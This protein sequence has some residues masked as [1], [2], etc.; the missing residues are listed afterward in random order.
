MNF[1]LK[2][3]ALSISLAVATI[4]ASAQ[5]NRCAVL[6]H[7]AYLEKQNPKRAQQRA[8]FEQRAAAFT[9]KMAAS[10]TTM[11]NVTIP[12]VVHV[13]Y[14]SPTQNISDAQVLS[15]IE[16]L[17]KDFNR[18][19]ADT[20]N[21]PAAFQALGASAGVTFCLAQIDPLGNPTNGIERRSTSTGSFNT[22]DNI[23]FFSSG[24]LDAWDPSQYFNIW[25]GPLGGGLLGYAE[26][27]TGALSNTYGVVIGYDCFGTIGTAAA[28]FDL[29]RTATHEVGHCFNLFHI[30]GD[31]GS[32]C[33]GS[34]NVA[35][36]PNQGGENYFCPSYPNTDN[37]ATT[38]P[39]VMHM[40][41]MDYTDDA[42]MNIFTAGQVARMLAVVNSAPYNQLTASTVCNPPVLVSVDAMLASIQNPDGNECNSTFTP[43]ITLK[44]MGIDTLFSVDINYYVDNNTA[45]VYNWTGVLPSQASTG[46]TLPLI[47]TN[48][49]AHTFSVFT[50]QP[51]STGDLNTSND[52]AVSS[53]TVVS[54]GATLPY[55]E[56]FEASFPPAG[57][58]LVNPDNLTTFEQTNAAAHSGTNSAY[59]NNFDY[60]SNGEIDELILPGIDLNGTTAPELSFYLAYRL[61]TSPTANPNYS[62][63]LEILISTDCGD[64][65]NS[66][67]KK[68]STALV[69]TGA[70]FNT[71][72]AFV[73]TSAQWRRDSIDL[74]AFTTYS[75]VTIKFHHITDYENNL[76]LDD[77]NIDVPATTGISEGNTLSAVSLFP[78]PANETIRLNLAGVTETGIRMQLMD[79]TGRLLQT[80]ENLSGGMNYDFDIENL[81]AGSYVVMIVSGGDVKTLRFTKQ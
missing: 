73:P 20:V 35:D 29:G 38:A 13:L 26:F 79:A 1:K 31:D 72:V 60:D 2:G 46:I 19:N 63:T 62:D 65:Y 36:T 51:N 24:G 16:V 22:N 49:G 14:N 9:T 66:V 55:Q 6:E 75:N 30:W 52:T 17:N 68:F 41:Y 5:V 10:K 56:G 77:I 11:P 37:C 28:P 25:V 48:A 53:F 81:A 18:L 50:S 70:P 78:N 47:S 54:A 21:T 3:L 7:E 40:N 44:N 27:P 64:T 42:C 67:Y 32:A 58:T 59:I 34:D 15:Q 71:A 74:S 39:G 45:Q 43:E 80:Q 12:V 23:K 76:F 57:M 33:S 69:T 4:S 61:Y 8:S